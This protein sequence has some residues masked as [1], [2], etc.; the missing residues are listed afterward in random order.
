[1]RRSSSSPEMLE[2]RESSS[3]EESE[4]SRGRIFLCGRGD[5]LEYSEELYPKWVFTP[6]NILLSE[7]RVGCRMLRYWDRCS[8]F[9]S[10]SAK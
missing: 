9:S 7:W 3:E 10:S 4:I 6:V 5:S 8:F 1:M 2:S